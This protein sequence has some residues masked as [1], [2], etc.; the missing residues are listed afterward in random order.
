M[1][2]VYW[3][4]MKIEKKKPNEIRKYKYKHSLAMLEFEQ[5]SKSTTGSHNYIE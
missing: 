3:K 1:K 2:V 4:H 5:Y